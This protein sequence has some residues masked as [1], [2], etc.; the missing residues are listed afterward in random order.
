MIVGSIW[1]EIL[2]INRTNNHYITIKYC[3][4]PTIFDNVTLKCI[5]CENLF[6]QLRQTCVEKCSYNEYQYKSDGICYITCPEGLLG[7]KNICHQ[8]CVGLSVNDLKEEGGK[9]VDLTFNLKSLSGKLSA[10]RDQ[11]ISLE[12]EEDFP[13]ERLKEI[14]MDKVSSTKCNKNF[15]NFYYIL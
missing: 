8:S 15:L 9:C 5:R 7:Y 2:K 6:S 1:F 12:F 11:I 4:E 10:Q 3:E 14:S 13:E